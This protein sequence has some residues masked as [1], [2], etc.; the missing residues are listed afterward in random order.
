M[1]AHYF[2]TMDQPLTSTGSSRGSKQTEDTVLDLAIELA[3]SATLARALAVTLPA[4][5][6]LFTSDLAVFAVAGAAGSGATIFPPNPAAIATL[7]SAW[8]E[9]WEDGPLS[10]WLRT[11]LLWTPI[12][13]SDIVDTTEWNAFPSI[14]TDRGPVQYLLC[15]PV[16]KPSPTV[17]CAYFLARADQDFD[18]AD[19]QLATRIQPVLIASHAR[20]LKDLTGNNPLTS[21]ESQVLQLMSTGLTAVTIGA[22]LG[23]SSHTVRKHLQNAYESLGVHDR[24]A[25]ITEMRNLGTAETTTYSWQEATFPPSTSGKVRRP[26]L[27]RS[28]KQIG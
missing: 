26:A 9:L 23:I 16:L 8:Q 5:A 4:L 15:L 17:L 19:M 24:A 10:R 13:S 11:H 21:R 2:G 25:A 1:Q 27:D 7:T 22:H 3:D 12:R 20:Y 28:D 6:G 14:F 18:F